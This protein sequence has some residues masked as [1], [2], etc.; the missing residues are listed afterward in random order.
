[1]GFI[2]IALS[3]VWANYA[4]AEKNSYFKT[5][6]T[7]AEVQQTQL[8]EYHNTVLF[9]GNSDLLSISSNQSVIGRL[10]SLIL[11]LID[12]KFNLSVLQNAIT[13][14]ESGNIELKYEKF[15]FSGHSQ[16]ASHVAYLSKA[17][18][19]HRAILFSGPQ[20]LI[21]RD[22]KDA[23]VSWLLGPFKTTSIY[24]FMH[25]EEEGTADLIQENWHLMEPLGVASFPQEGRKHLV[26]VQIYSSY[27]IVDCGLTWGWG[28]DGMD[29]T[30]RNAYYERS[31]ADAACTSRRCFY[32]KIP[33][34]ASTV[35]RVSR[36]NHG[37]TVTDN[38]TPT[39]IAADGT[40]KPIYADD[41]WEILLAADS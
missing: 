32:S 29:S 5:H 4:D 3:Y 6:S 26:G 23:M 12:Q 8:M 31:R 13:I 1:M 20:D 7:E 27:S 38:L 19:L 18:Q 41:I 17:V 22:E 37:S 28:K 14:S 16:G 34:A 35:K 11:K 15:I 39:W 10:K 9:G 24:A 25:A 36:P 30:E 2:T 40:D 21:S 33:P